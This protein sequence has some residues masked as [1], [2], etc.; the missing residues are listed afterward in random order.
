MNEENGIEF[1]NEIT[2]E[3]N[4]FNTYAVINNT[5]NVVTALTFFIFTF[6]MYK[7]LKAVFR[8]KIDMKKRNFI[9]IFVIFIFFFNVFFMGKSNAISVN[10]NGNILD[11][12]DV[13]DEA[14][15]YVIFNAR[16]QIRLSYT[17]DSNCVK[18]QLRKSLMSYLCVVFLDESGNCLSEKRFSLKDN[19]WNFVNSGT[20]G[21]ISG[22]RYVEPDV[23]FSNVEIYNV[24]NQLYYA[25]KYSF[26]I[27]YFDD[28][29]YC[30]I[31]SGYFDISDFD[32]TNCEISSDNVNFDIV[33][34]QGAA[35]GDDEQFVNFVFWHD[36]RKN[37]TYYIRYT[38]TDGTVLC[39]FK[40]LIN[41]IDE[42]YDPLNF[43][44][45]TEEKTTELYI[46]SNEFIFDSWD[47]YNFD[48]D[49]VMDYD[50]EVCFGVDSKYEKI[51]PITEY[52]NDLTR[53]SSR[54]EYQV[55]ANGVYKFRIVE[56]ATKKVVEKTFLI[57]N[58]L[59]ENP[60]RR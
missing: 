32:I 58:Y 35:L 46:L 41:E 17:T 51:Y 56:K 2:V 36:I 9:I 1:L 30:Q 33:N 55:F 45:S 6:F 20:D 31:T 60:Y 43:H 59:I 37:G 38:K 24:D 3:D 10:F 50:V 25:P 5:Y 23:Y 4:N 42:N 8:R 28:N 7:Y 52:N 54:F 13:P 57:N 16:G 26:E 40:L 12:P 49:F 47:N 14:F 21:L 39:K 22:C 11:F 29:S 18:I 19:E 53:Y 48:D 44:L 34:K 15:S 27:N